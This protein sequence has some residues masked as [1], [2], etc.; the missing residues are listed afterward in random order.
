MDIRVG[1]RAQ[2]VIPAAIRRQLGI[3]EGDLLH[4]EVDAAGRLVLE[5]VAKDPVARLRA[6]GRGLYDAVDAVAE[7]RALRSEWPR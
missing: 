1:R 3:G 4:A 6:A 2:I 5:P 7:Q